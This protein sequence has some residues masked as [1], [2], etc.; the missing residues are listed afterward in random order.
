MSTA[1]GGAWT[2]AA[3]SG[4]IDPMAEWFHLIWASLSAALVT[5]LSG[6][7]VGGAWTG[8]SGPGPIGPMV[9]WFHLMWASL[10]AALVTLSGT[11]LLADR[12]RR[13]EERRRER[14]AFAQAVLRCCDILDDIS[15]RYWGR[16]KDEG[17]CGEMK[18]LEAQ[19]KAELDK[20]IGH[21]STSSRLDSNE[22]NDLREILHR[23]QKEM[24]ND[25]E[26]ATRSANPKMVGFILGA[27][28][29]IRFKVNEMSA[30]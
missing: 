7:W 8:T 9:E 16:G 12:L 29:R 6:A 28:G 18:L 14:R 21:V 10:S 24:E 30:G 17:N 4:P 3:R 5:S 26:Y 13:G 25:F 22:R 23:V 11:W 20:I 1:F 27:I 15:V 2:G 19:V